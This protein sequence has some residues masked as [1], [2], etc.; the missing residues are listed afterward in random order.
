LVMRSLPIVLLFNVIFGINFQFALSFDSQAINIYKQITNSMSLFQKQSNDSTDAQMVLKSFHSSIT[1]GSMTY[2]FLPESL[3]WAAFD[4]P[5]AID[6]TNYNK[7]CLKSWTK[8]YN[9]SIDKCLSTNQERFDCELTNRPKTDECDT[10][11]Y[12]ES[13]CRKSVGGLGSKMDEIVFTDGRSLESLIW[14]CS[15]GLE[16]SSFGCVPHL[17]ST[18]LYQQHA[19]VPTPLQS[20]RDI[21]YVLLKVCILFYRMCPSLLLHSIL[22]LSPQE[23]SDPCPVSLSS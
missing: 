10:N 15:M 2:S 3:G 20:A 22:C 7:S 11:E 18:I 14:N 6:L 12:R 8:K 1:V 21:L 13:N 5:H 16:C 19:T 23:I 9:Q 17:P 4:H